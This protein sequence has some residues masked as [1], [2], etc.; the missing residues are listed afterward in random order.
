M[1]IVQLPDHNKPYLLFTDASKFCYS[2]ELTQASI[3]ETNKVLIMLL[4]DKDPSQKCPIPNTGPSTKFCSPPCG[5]K[6][7]ASSIYVLNYLLLLVIT[8]K[9]LF[10]QLFSQ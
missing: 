3:D 4:T 1:P 10:F 5:C 9:L 8:C 7:Q 2:E 6:D